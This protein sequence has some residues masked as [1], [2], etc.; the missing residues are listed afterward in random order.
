MED[1]SQDFYIHLS[2]NA[3]GQ[4]VVNALAKMGAMNY[5]S[6]KTLSAGGVQFN[7]GVGADGNFRIGEAT[8]QESV[9]GGNQLDTGANF[10]S[11]QQ[12]FVAS[13]GDANDI[14]GF[15]N[16]V[17]N[18]QLSDAHKKN[19]FGHVT[20]GVANATGLEQHEVDTIRNYYSKSLKREVLILT[21]NLKNSEII[22]DAFTSVDVSF[23]VNAIPNK[24][25]LDK[26]LDKDLAEIFIVDEEF[27][28]TSGS[29]YIDGLFE[30]YTFLQG[31]AKALQF[32]KKAG[33][34][35][36]IEAYIKLPLTTNSVKAAL[37]NI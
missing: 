11:A 36:Y 6:S 8:A 17:K 20:A 22:K 10:K 12:A 29:D 7:L 35:N 32:S 18:S 37:K 5:A 27:D 13:G 4:D 25:M 28:G 30:S 34:S 31:H 1:A 3:K 15:V 26:R 14:Q 16:Y 2:Q 21:N 33:A 19:I 9:K 23:N 24:K